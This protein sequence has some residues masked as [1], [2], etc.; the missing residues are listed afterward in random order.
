MKRG[1]SF[2]NCDVVT[3]DN[4]SLLTVKWSKIGIY[5]FAF[6]RNI[7]IILSTPVDSFY[8]KEN[9]KWYNFTFWKL[10]YLKINVR[11]TIY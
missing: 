2:K 3:N 5:T 8:C 10:N 1:K 7:P 9:S 11:G 4:K 6:A